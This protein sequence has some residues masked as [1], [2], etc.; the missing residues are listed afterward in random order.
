MARIADGIQYCEQALAIDPLLETA[1][2]GLIKG[3]LAVDDLAAAKQ[4]SDSSR[5]EAAVPMTMISLYERDWLRAGEAAYEALARRT[6]APDVQGM[7]L[8]AIRMHARATGDFA[9]AAPPSSP[10]PTSAG[11]RPGG[12]C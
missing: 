1:R 4:L 3:Y 7:I 11:M 10:S 9:R 5:G 2:R 12:R 8:R 6:G